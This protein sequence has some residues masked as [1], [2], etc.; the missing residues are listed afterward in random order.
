MDKTKIK[1]LLDKY[2]QG[3]CTE[4][5]RAQLE[6]WYLNQEIPHKLPLT[7]IEF[8][9]ELHKIWS[10]LEEEHNHRQ[11]TPLWRKLTVAASIVLIT[12]IGLYGYFTNKGTGTVAPILKQQAIADI[13]PGGDKAVFIDAQGNVEDLKDQ[14][15]VAPATLQDAGNKSGYSTVIT[16]KGGQY[17]VILPDGT[18]VWLNA[19]SSLKYPNVFNGKDR[20]VELTGEAYFEVKHDAS[21][22]FKVASLTQTVEVLGTHFNVNTYE[23]EPSIKTTLLEGSV[24]V[25]TANVKEIV[26]KPGEQSVNLHGK[27]SKQNVGVNEVVAW[28]NGF[29][30]FDNASLETVMRQISRWYDLDI[31]YE[32][33]VPERVFNGKVYRNMSLSKVLS[34]LSFSNINYRIH[35]KTMIISS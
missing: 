31:Q 6:T 26:L 33:N 13:K 7:E 30:Q 3:T 1:E 28:K 19:A 27:I 34:V 24:R 9:D 16:P 14:I 12:G 18:H 5:E 11:I 22:P 21:K 35:G 8:E 32:G 15:F 29:F 25:T 4:L 23:D 2:E 10:S 17:Q 20:R